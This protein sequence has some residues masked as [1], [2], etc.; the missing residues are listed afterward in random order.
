MNDEAD[1]EP[2]PPITFRTTKTMFMQH[3][4]NLCFGYWPWLTSLRLSFTWWVVLVCT[5][6]KGHDV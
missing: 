6:S 1:L 3:L 5:S 2:D 4:Y